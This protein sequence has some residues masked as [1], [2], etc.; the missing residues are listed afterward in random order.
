MGGRR[1]RPSKAAWD[2]AMD[3]LLD[4][5]H[6]HGE[7]PWH[8]LVAVGAELRVA[9]LSVATRYG[10]FLRRIE[11]EHDVVTLVDTRCDV[12]RE[13]RSLAAAYR[14]LAQKGCLVPFALF[15]RA[16]WREAGDR[17]LVELRRAECER[18]SMTEGFGNCPICISAMEAEAAA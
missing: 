6:L 16:V 4:Q 12:I 1:T 2:S 13:M 5:H 15:E 10:C 18:R 9:P 8:V 11:L 3:R 17:D 7:M 14:A